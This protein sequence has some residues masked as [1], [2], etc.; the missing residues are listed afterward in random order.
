MLFFR[1]GVTLLSTLCSVAVVA[2]FVQFIRFGTIDW[3]IVAAFLLLFSAMGVMFCAAIAVCTPKNV[4]M[5]RRI[6]ILLNL[7][8]VR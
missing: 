7:D 6:A 8:Y 4:P 3:N 5:H 1:I 2:L